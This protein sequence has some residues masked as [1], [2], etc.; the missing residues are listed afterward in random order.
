MHKN[1][2]SMTTARAAAHIRQMRGLAVMLD[3]DLAAL[4]GV[5][6]NEIRSA[7]ARQPEIFPADFVCELPGI[8]LAFNEQGASM[9]AAMFS[10]SHSADVGIAIMRGFRL[11]RRQR[12][13]ARTTMPASRLGDRR[14]A[15]KLS[16]PRPRNRKSK[17]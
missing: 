13:P 2:E 17:F 10:N 12:P 9:F 11:L 4:Y 16:A 3:A 7:V 15:R 1:T 6:L 8:G 14:V 5:D